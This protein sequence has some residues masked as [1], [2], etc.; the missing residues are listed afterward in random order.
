MQ[1]E[2]Y[3]G[4]T[5]PGSITAVNTEN[6]TVSKKFALPQIDL[7]NPHNMWTDRAHKVVYVNEWFGDK[8][9]V[10]DRVTGQVIRRLTVGPSPAHV[11]TRTDTDQLHIGLNG[12][13]AVV[14]A[15]PGATK[16][17]R[18]ISV[19]KPGQGI[20][21]PHAH[22]MSGDAKYMIAPDANFDIA[23]LVNIGPGTIK[24]QAFV[25]SVPIASG[26]SS[27]GKK[28]YVA[29]LMSN[30]LMCISNDKP[31]CVSNG[32]K[33]MSKKIDLFTSVYDPVTGAS[34]KPGLLPGIL[35]IQNAVSP[36]NQTML[37]ADAVS[38]QISVIDPQTDKLIKTIP[39]D[40]GC[41]GINWGA[42]KGGGYYG[43]VSSKFANT[44]IVIDGD[45]NADGNPA[46]AKMV[47]HMVMNPDAGTKMDDTITAYPG[48]GG[49][50]VLPLPLV[51]NG[52]VQHD[53][54][55]WKAKLTC[56]QRDPLNTKAC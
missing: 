9:N 21:H 1:M 39:C 41:H 4:K 54:A 3:A 35:P 8:V 46:D 32:K 55:A 30:W 36:D 17:D 43:Y 13:N 12:G 48:M 6:W 10:V 38:G 24:K 53:P 28:S 51:Y 14:E 7:N 49:Q 44:L 15:A 33:V 25:G 56:Q 50:G 23:T 18:R 22:W 29:S 5:K 11:M 20:A 19:T 45:P 34:K 52:W 37:V 40:P 16:I 27:D 2:Q 47:G 42:K 26:M 31:A